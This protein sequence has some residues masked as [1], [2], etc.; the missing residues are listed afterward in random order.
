MTL[1]E[2]QANAYNE[3]RHRFAVSRDREDII[4][5]SPK[6]KAIAEQI[7]ELYKQKA[8]YESV[9]GHYRVKA[10]YSSHNHEYAVRNR[11][12]AQQI[13]AQSKR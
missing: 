2:I 7:D 12:K 8:N 6:A 1:A 10:N 13:D 3:A 5:S 4:K 11:Q 9:A